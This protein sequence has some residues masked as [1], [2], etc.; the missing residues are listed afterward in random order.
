MNLKKMEA[1]VRQLLEGM[2]MDLSDPNFEDTPRRVAKMYAELLTPG[3][4]SWTV[5][6]TTKSD[7]VLLRGHQVTIVCPHH[8][9]P[10]TIRCH[11]AYIPTKKTLGLSKLARA[12]EQFLTRPILQEELAEVV[13]DVLEEKLEPKGVAVI[14]AGRHG[15]MIHRGVKS[16]GDVV[17]SVVRGVFLLNPAARAELFQLVGRP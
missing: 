11:I 16:D 8:L 13:A 7:L 4:N 3:H 10:A 9:A 12:V 5:F 1:G 15:C 14:L 6:P 17:T 2:E